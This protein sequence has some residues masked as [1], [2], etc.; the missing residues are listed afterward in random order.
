MSTLV[1]ASGSPRRVDL[2]TQLLGPSAFVVEPADIDEDDA[3]LGHD[4]PAPLVAA[5]ARA[6]A[7]AVWQPGRTVLA[8][9]TIVR[10]QRQN[11]GKPID[12]TA[13]AATISS[14]RGD[15]V[16]VWSAVVVTGARGARVDEVVRTTL[17]MARPD[18]DAIAAYVATG[19]ADDKAGG[20]AVQD[21]AGPFVD[22][23]SGCVTN[24]YGLPLCATARLL[25]HAGLLLPDSAP[26]C[27]GCD[28]TDQH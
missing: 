11:L 19:A 14:M 13:A 20:L 8:A 6:K 9:D 5:V 12:R 2:L 15:A 23:I 7:A 28:S 18:D 22:R 16:D 21:G 3:G 24:V 4:Q 27:P 25:G 1:L 26:S 17:H 10:H